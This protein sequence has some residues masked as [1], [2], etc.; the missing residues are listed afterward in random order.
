MVTVIYKKRRK[1]GVVVRMVY[2][3]WLYGGGTVATE[4]PVLPSLIFSLRCRVPVISIP[5]KV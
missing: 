3:V 1:G 2:G 4:C 5:T